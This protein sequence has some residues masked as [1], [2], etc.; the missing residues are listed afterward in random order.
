[1]LKA[2]ARPRRELVA[3]KPPDDGSSSSATPASSS[4][5]P[6][7]ICDIPSA[8]SS[9][10]VRGRTAGTETEETGASLSDVEEGSTTTEEEEPV[11]LPEPRLPFDPNVPGPSGIAPVIKSKKTGSPPI[12]PKRREREILGPRGDD[13]TPEQVSFIERGHLATD[14]DVDLTLKDEV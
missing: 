8:T 1:L 10:V 3:A 9:P 6:S 2:R 5:D 4:E 11:S 7:R 14:H 13:L 12:D